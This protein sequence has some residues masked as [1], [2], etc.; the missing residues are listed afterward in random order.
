MSPS[1][2]IQWRSLGR[3]GQREASAPRSLSQVS[4]RKL[5]LESGFVQGVP[6]KVKRLEYHSGPP[7][8]FGGSQ[9]CEIFSAHQDV[10]TGFQGLAFFTRRPRTLPFLFS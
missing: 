10:D 9:K 5:N 1:R 8:R 4:M 7:I 3:R 6:N 2:W